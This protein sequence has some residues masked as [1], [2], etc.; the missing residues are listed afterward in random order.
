MSNPNFVK[1]EKSAG[2]PHP[3]AAQKA[4]PLSE[5]QL[6]ATLP[7][8]KKS[9][10][11]KSPE[12]YFRP[13]L[14]YAVD[15]QFVSFDEVQ[16]LY[17]GEKLVNRVV[18][19][20]KLG[21]KKFM[22]PF[23]NVVETFLNIPNI[24]MQ[25]WSEVFYARMVQ[26][27]NV[28]SPNH[29]EALR[30][31]VD[32][33]VQQLSVAE[34][35]SH[36]RARSLEVF[37]S[38]LQT[39]R[40]D[41]DSALIGLSPGRLYRSK[42]EKFLTSRDTHKQLSDADLS[43]KQLLDMIIDWS[44]GHDLERIGKK[45]KAF[46]H[47]MR[48]RAVTMLSEGDLVICQ[49]PWAFVFGHEGESAAESDGE[50]AAINAGTI[51]RM[52]TLMSRKQIQVEDDNVIIARFAGR[53]SDGVLVFHT[54]QE[55]TKVKVDAATVFP[56]SKSMLDLLGQAKAMQALVSDG[57]DKLNSYLRDHLKTIVALFLEEHDITLDVLKR[58]NNNEA[59]LL[60][61]FTMRRYRDELDAI[62][63]A[64]D[65]L[66]NRVDS[67]STQIIAKFTES[68][69]HRDLF[70]PVR[71]QTLSELGSWP[72]CSLAKSRIKRWQGVVDS[73]LMQ[74]DID[75]RLILNSTRKLQLSEWWLGLIRSSVKQLLM[76]NMYDF[77]AV[78]SNY[79]ESPP[80]DME[81]IRQ[82]LELIQ[83]ILSPA[84]DKHGVV[85]KLIKPLTERIYPKLD[86]LVEMMYIV[87]MD[88]SFDHGQTSVESFNQSQ[89]EGRLREMTGEPQG[90]PE[91]V[92]AR[93]HSLL[94]D[95]RY[96][97]E[98]KAHE[99]NFRKQ[100][101]KEVPGLQ[102]SKSFVMVDAVPVSGLIMNYFHR[103]EVELKTVIE[104]WQDQDTIDNWHRQR[105]LP[106]PARISRP[107]RVVHN[108]LPPGARGSVLA[109]ASDSDEAPAPGPGPGP[110]LASGRA[111]LLKSPSAKLVVKLDKKASFA[112]GRGGQLAKVREKAIAL[113]RPPS[114]MRESDSEGEGEAQRPEVGSVVLRIRPVT[115][116]DPSARLSTHDMAK[117]S[118]R[119]V[120]ANAN[121]LP[122][123]ES[124]RSKASMST[125]PQEGFALVPGQEDPA[126]S[127][128][129][130][131]KG[132][133]RG[134][135]DL[136]VPTPR[137]Y[138]ETAEAYEEEAS[139]GPPDLEVPTPRLLEETAAQEAHG[140]EE[141]Q[142]PLDE[143]EGVSEGAPPPFKHVQ[144]DDSLVHVLP[145][146]DDDDMIISDF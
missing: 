33:Y 67:F 55:L 68:M 87:L 39:H 129:G 66:L 141:E 98:M 54:A 133:P 31:V 144:T 93:L 92:A 110:G 130:E 116:A 69:Q 22:K 100:P 134:P 44:E 6:Q 28:L 99:K 35:Q 18:P 96:I 52:N 24:Y 143:D 79:I 25:T 80:D 57:A 122:L 77:H 121:K 30:L 89:Y 86:E 37:S 73:T 74:L 88:Q 56:F 111:K 119:S 120:R 70:Q 4:T 105:G 137:L 60:D 124:P 146:C 41:P 90:P 16:D 72:Y 53:D 109:E 125:S 71:A 114:L 142:D 112:G 51:R 62:V 10:H 59:T 26:F 61:L 17:P 21:S 126:S 11:L 106:V 83:E 118:P 81:S 82:N 48:H 95:A 38:F 23:A 13:M 76:D 3:L 85:E 127:S 136:E 128:A 64:P 42:Y 36:L 132:S 7:P 78:N 29:L 47:N 84:V 75:R 102:R 104:L 97:H 108:R 15:M 140:S 50:D 27:Q 138:E 9:K 115:F 135:P 117:L 8:M 145:M 139:V 40:Y 131:S 20:A 14:Q 19:Q 107:K 123:L 49:L 45:V 103:M 63:A 32:Y 94:K 34:R 43:K 2:R 113:P 101:E 5:E 65:E 91:E 12:S 58:A 46:V 1:K